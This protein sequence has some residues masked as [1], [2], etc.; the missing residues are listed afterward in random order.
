MK[1]VFLFCF[2]GFL[3]KTATAQVPNNALFDYKSPNGDI[4]SVRLDSIRGNQSGGTVTAVTGSGTGGATV[5]VTNGTTTPNVAVA[6]SAIPN[7][8]L[9]NSSV[10]IAGQTVA[11][12]GTTTLGFSNLTGSATVAQLPLSIPNANLANS[13]VTVAGV[14]IP[15]GGSGAINFTNLTG[16]ASLSQLPNAGVTTIDGQSVQLGG[17]FT[18]NVSEI[19]TTNTD[20]IS[21]RVVVI[22]ATSNIVVTL[23]ASPPDGY[24]KTYKRTGGVGIPTIVANSGQTIQD[25]SQLRLISVGRSV[26]LRYAAYVNAWVVI[27]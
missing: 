11:L 20:N 22:F 1:K 3:V 19:G 26:T 27:D 24:S 7:A 5:T 17:V 2:F 15:L 16:S 4:G 21:S 25:Y 14:A 10:T 23:P 18:Q 9:A 12:G 13:S 6:L 8:S